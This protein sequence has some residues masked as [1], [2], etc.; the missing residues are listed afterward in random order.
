VRA[1]TVVPLKANSAEV[2]DLPD[3]EPRE[4]ELLV[5]GVALGICGTD[6][7]IVRG[8]YGWAPPGEE[9]LVLG[10]ESLGRVREAPEGSG[11]A[12]GDLVVGVVRRPD[13]VPCVP[14][15]HGEFDMCRNG[16]YTERGIKEIHGYGSE[17]WTVEADYAVKLDPSLESVGML[18]EP[19]TILAKAW[20][21]IE[22]IGSRYTFEASSVLVTG[23]GP[24]GL[25]G[26][27]LGTQRGLQVNVLDQVTEGPKPRLVED[28]G[29]TYYT[30]DVATAVGK[31][32]PDIIIEATGVAQLVLE[33]MQE[34][35]SGGITCLTGVS[36]AGRDLNVDA[37]A[38]NRE[39]VL[40]NDVVF[41]SVNANLRHYKAAAEAL[42]QADRSWLERLIT[43]RVPL[44][45]FR[46]A[47]ERQPDDVKVV[48]ELGS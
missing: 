9:R 38:L 15:G 21:H 36:P 25:L 43:R 45:R 5:D 20:D 2:I 46:E 34:T 17:Q 35:N 28:L 48:I 42:A 37:G 41:G 47:L 19:T 30:G 29:G 33:A 14:C 7:E 23:A 40:E 32:K 16:L 11:F 1:L 22:R 18:M 6:L 4:G 44:E 26:A 39:L 3:P 31:C 12:K 27:L 13:P 8:E 24:I 10:H